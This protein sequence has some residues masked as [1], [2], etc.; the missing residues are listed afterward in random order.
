MNL[1]FKFV[2]GISTV[3]MLFFSSLRE[4]LLSDSLM[5]PEGITDFMSFNLVMLISPPKI[6][7]I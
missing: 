7:L 3:S 5:L 1:S 2:S 4:Y 6:P